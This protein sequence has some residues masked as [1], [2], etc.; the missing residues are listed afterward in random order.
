MALHRTRR[1]FTL[2]EVMIVLGVIS[3]IALLTTTEMGE[4]LANQR[5]KAAARG[6]ADAF[7]LARAEAIRTGDNHV[8][9][10]GPPGT[11]DPAGTVLTGFGGASVPIIVSNDGPP[12]TANCMLDG[13]ERVEMLR[14]GDDW[15]W[16]VSRATTAVSDDNG[17]ALFA[18][19]QANGGTF[20]DPS[21]NLANW[22]LF[23][24][25]GIP[26]AFSHN[27][28][29][30]DD[31][32]STGSSGAALYFTNGERD[33]AVVLSPLGGVRVHRWEGNG[34]SI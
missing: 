5:V 28:G 9:Y 10:F 27:A 30:C 1:G 11:T 32:G 6:A 2:I 34:W 14:F 21:N 23:R 17:A 22:V 15:Q 31:M 29:A 20:S 8:V 33:Y 13:G 19:P 16:G 3:A 4:W 25:D 26:V 24:P 7:L 18:A 12:A